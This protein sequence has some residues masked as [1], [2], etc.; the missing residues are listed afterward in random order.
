MLVAPGTRQNWSVTSRP[1]K[2]R[3]KGNW[4]SNGDDFMPVQVMMVRVGMRSPE[5]STAPSSVA[6][7]RPVLRRISRPNCS[8]RFSA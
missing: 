4:A 7:C 6:A 3:S 5:L 2:S 8:T 1:R